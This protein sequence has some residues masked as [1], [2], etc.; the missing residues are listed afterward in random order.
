MKLSFLLFVGG[1]FLIFVQPAFSQ[2]TITEN[3]VK[4]K[5]YPYSDP[6]PVARIT[7]FYPYFRFDGFTDTS[8]EKEWKIITLE[9]EYIKVYVA[10][11]IGGKVLGAIEKSTG[12]EFIYFNKVVKFRD[13]AMR[14]A[15]TSG[16]IEFNFGSI[17]HAPTTASSVNYLLK[18][19][20]DGSVSCIVGAPEITSR[21]EWRVEIRLPANASYFETK[22]LWYNPSDQKTSLYNWM[23]ASVDASYDLEYFFPGHSEI[24]HGGESGSWP[25]N[26]DGIKISEYKNNTFGGPK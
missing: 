11:E 5:T 19:N 6:D 20:D 25:V 23:T 14:G 22:A 13:I 8:V 9:N 2:A 16:G 17:G 18:N 26:K 1:I 4:F 3:A 15:W 21:T 24:G 7:K 12:E 10:P